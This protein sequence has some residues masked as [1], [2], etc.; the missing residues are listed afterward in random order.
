MRV[1]VDA[2]AIPSRRLGVGT[3]V[4]E[5]LRC[6]R[7]VD[8]H[9]FVNAADAEEL[10]AILPAVTIHPVRVPNRVARIA[11]SQAVLPLR[12]RTIAPDLFHGPHYE[13][14]RGL[15]CPSVVT[16]HDPTF[17]TMPHVHERA[18]VAY[19]TRVARTGVARAT[20]VIAV[21]DYAR[22]GAIEHAGADPSRVDVVHEGID[23]DRYAPADDVASTEPYV[24]F[25]GAL[26]PHK[27]VP[28][29]IAA[30]DA[31]EHPDTRLLIAGQPAWGADAVRS[32]IDAARTRDAIHLLGFISDEEKIERMQHASAFVYPS[33]AEGFGLPVLEAMACGA[34]VITTTGSAPEEFAA[35][36]AVLV[37]PGDTDALRDALAAV[38]ADPAKRAELRRLGPQRAARFSWDAAADATVDVW[39]RAAA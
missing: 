7:D 15:R 13:V 6:V 22:R 26:A 10:S 37:P 35:G 16:F 30:F 9:V 29:L 27:N 28:S 21:S 1:A 38:L 24:F 20:R 32:A 39:K 8:L 33:L 36:A 5:L 3:Y 17:F 12:L 11:W 31:L 34:P 23:L 19:F 2:T 25:V 14:P 18:K 4:T